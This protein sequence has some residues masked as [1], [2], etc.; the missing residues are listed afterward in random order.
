[1]LLGEIGHFRRTA[2]KDLAFFVAG[3]PNMVDNKFGFFYG[4][5]SPVTLTLHCNSVLKRTALRLLKMEACLPE[6]KP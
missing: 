3:P 6:K 4:S 2:D 1:M 5:V